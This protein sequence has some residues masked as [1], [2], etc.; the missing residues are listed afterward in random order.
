MLDELFPVYGV[1]MTMLIAG[2]NPNTIPEIY[3][4]TTIIQE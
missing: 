4:G 3:N 2:Y 1:Y